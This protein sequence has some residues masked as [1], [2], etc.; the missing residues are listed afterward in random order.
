MTKNHPRHSMARKRE[1]VEAYF[2]GES[3]RGLS[4]KYNICRTLIAIWSRSTSE[5]SSMTRLWR[6]FLCRSTRLGSLPSNGLPGAKPSRSGAEQWI[7]SLRVKGLQ[8]R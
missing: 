5:V 8:S 1:V 2:N 6:S 3:M 4:Q 7:L